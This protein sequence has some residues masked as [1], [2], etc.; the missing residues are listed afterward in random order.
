MPPIDS[1]CTLDPRPG[2]ATGVS[3][4]SFQGRKLPAAPVNWDYA[5]EFE[6]AEL[7]VE[8]VD[9]VPVAIPWHRIGDELGSDLLS[10]V[11]SASVQSLR[12]IHIPCLRVHQRD[13]APTEH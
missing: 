10:I 9:G 3:G 5:R 2:S 12:G 13:P 6:G 1:E 7:G 11:G 8:R 4:V